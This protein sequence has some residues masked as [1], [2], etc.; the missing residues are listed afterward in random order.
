MKYS[1]THYLVTEGAIKQGAN[2]FNTKN[3]YYRDG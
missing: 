2:N 3:W 1:D